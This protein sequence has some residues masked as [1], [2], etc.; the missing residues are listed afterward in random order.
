M[1]LLKNVGN[2]IIN[3]L[4]SIINF[5]K[6]VVQK[7]IN[8]I[9][10]LFDFCKSVSLFLFSNNNTINEGNIVVFILLISTSFK[11]ISNNIDNW[12]EAITTIATLY[13]LYLFV[14]T[15]NSEISAKDAL[16]NVKSIITSKKTKDEK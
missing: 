4:K 9:K 3:L 2:Y 16:N 7:I 12:P 11:I 10:S 6:N 13:I 1:N 8:L 14:K 5:P 15:E